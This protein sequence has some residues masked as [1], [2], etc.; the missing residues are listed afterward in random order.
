MKRA[1]LKEKKAK[2]MLL[3]RARKEAKAQG[4]PYYYTGKKCANGHW[5]K[6]LTSNGL[7]VGCRAVSVK[8]HYD[9]WLSKK[10]R[11]LNSNQNQVTTA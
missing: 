5:D 4:E 7:C 8:K 9:K 11:S 2:L 1:E 3:P 10:A 6:R